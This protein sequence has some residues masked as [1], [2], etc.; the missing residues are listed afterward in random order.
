MKKKEI[1]EFQELLATTVWA[2]PVTGEAIPKTLLKDFPELLNDTGAAGELL[3]EICDTTG[4]EH[5]RVLRFADGPEFI[6]QTHLDLFKITAH[7]LPLQYESLIGTTKKPDKDEVLQKSVKL[8]CQR[9]G[10]L[11]KL[12]RNSTSRALLESWNMVGVS[13]GLIDFGS[14][15]RPAEKMKRY[16]DKSFRPEPL[17]PGPKSQKDSVTRLFENVLENL[18]PAYQ[19]RSA[20]KKSQVCIEVINRY[21]RVGLAQQRTL[22]LP[23]K[24]ANS[25]LKSAATHLTAEILEKQPSQIKKY[26]SQT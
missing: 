14:S 18:R 5:G 8:L 6:V 24:L 7:W 13:Q 3:E 16:I 4:V 19:T 23:E 10:Y 21:K 22:D 26:I 12:L 1:K 15:G 17:K 11:R 25:G 9:L 2:D 20:L